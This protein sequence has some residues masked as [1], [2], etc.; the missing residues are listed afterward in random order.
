M[1]K[2]NRWG[3]LALLWTTLFSQENDDQFVR[4]IQFIGNESI[5]DNELRKVHNHQ[6]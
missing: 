5:S 2:K 3:I 1:Q 6:K 4:S